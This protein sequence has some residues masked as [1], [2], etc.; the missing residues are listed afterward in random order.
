MSI[1][2]NLIREE[3]VMDGL[4][5]TWKEDRDISFDSCHAEDAGGLCIGSCVVYP[6]WPGRDNGMAIAKCPK[7]PKEEENSSS[8]TQFLWLSAPL[9]TTIHVT[10]HP[11]SA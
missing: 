8:I 4:L 10:S 3:E 5:M 2:R 11:V 9:P 1:G 7:I 6:R